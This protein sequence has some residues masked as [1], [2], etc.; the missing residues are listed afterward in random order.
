MVST[1]GQNQDAPII[2]D[3]FYGQIMYEPVPV[4]EF[5][6]D[7]DHSGHVELP[8]PRHRGGLFE[9]LTRVVQ[10][11]DLCRPLLCPLDPEEFGTEEPVQKPRQSIF[12]FGRRCKSESELWA[13]FE[14]KL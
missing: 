8:K 4:L 9:G 5:S 12:T 10:D 7:V 11:L 13:N 6:K 2:R 3:C 14:H 1:V